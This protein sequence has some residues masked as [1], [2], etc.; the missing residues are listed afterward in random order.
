[1][2][3]KQSLGTIGLHSNRIEQSV[4]KGGKLACCVE[5]PWP[6]ECREQ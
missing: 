2:G 1:M 5:H 4:P 3:E 6:S